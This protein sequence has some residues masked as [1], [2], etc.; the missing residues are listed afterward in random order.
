MSNRSTAAH[1]IKYFLWGLT[2]NLDFGWPSLQSQ[3]ELERRKQHFSQSE[4]IG[5][6]A[7]FESCSIEKSHVR[8][9]GI[10]QKMS[11]NTSCSH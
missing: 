9:S 6:P 11:H 3:N 10:A 8:H 2:S 1:H 7:Y 5:P 4:G